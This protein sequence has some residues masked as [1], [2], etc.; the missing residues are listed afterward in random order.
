[1]VSDKYKA[2]RKKENR[3][4]AVIVTIGMIISCGASFWL[5]VSFHEDISPV[6]VGIIAGAGILFSASL[7]MMLNMMSDT[8]K[9]RRQS[10]HPAPDPR[11]KANK[12]EK[13][14]QKFIPHVL[15]EPVPDTPP[16]KPFSD[17]ALHR[18]AKGSPEQWSERTE[19][20]VIQLLQRFQPDERRAAQ[21]ILHDFKWTNKPN[22]LVAVLL[23]SRGDLKELE[24]SVK[25]GNMDFR[26]LMT[27]L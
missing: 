25:F 16:E 17:N 3:R 14:A 12:P 2:S 15:T 7:P 22:L 6:L 1:M 20:M 13:P 8:L 19:Q 11:K 5:L 4:E 10:A 27:G 24:K 23:Q 26:E 18:F 9:K 21:Q